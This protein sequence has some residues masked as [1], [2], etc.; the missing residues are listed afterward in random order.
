MRSSLLNNFSPSSAL[1]LR[2]YGE[3]VSPDLKPKAKVPEAAVFVAVEEEAEPESVTDE[4]EVEIVVDAP[5]VVEAA[6][7][8]V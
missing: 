5:V 3:D 7:D 8:T 1:S 2:L 6:S 4:V